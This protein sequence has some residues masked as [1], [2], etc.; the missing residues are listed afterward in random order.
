[1]LCIY[2]NDSKNIEVFSK[3]LYEENTELFS[4]FTKQFPERIC[5][6]KSNRKVDFGDE[7]RRICRLSNRAEIVNPN[8]DDVK[9][10]LYILKKYRN[11]DL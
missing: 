2:F 3:T 1:M 4:W 10:A 6:C 5:K 9:N 8:A 7:T 11:I